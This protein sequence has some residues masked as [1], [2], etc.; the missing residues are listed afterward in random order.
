MHLDQEV[1]INLELSSLVGCWLKIKTKQFWGWRDDSGLRD[2][3]VLPEDSVGFEFPEPTSDGST[4]PGYPIPSSGI[5][6][7]SSVCMCGCTCVFETRSDIIVK[8]NE[9]L[10]M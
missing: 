7:P 5:H 3:V 6:S 9:E 1:Q 10:T 8:P 2:L 4:A